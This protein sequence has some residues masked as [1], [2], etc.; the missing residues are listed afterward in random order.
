MD[1]TG[2]PLDHKQPKGIAPKG[3][4]PKG[5]KVSLWGVIRKQMSNYNTCLL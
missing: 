5:M 3:I 4:T 2:M 1:K